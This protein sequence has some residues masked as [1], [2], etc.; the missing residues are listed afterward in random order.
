MRPESPLGVSLRARLAP[1]ED[2]EKVLNAM[3]GI[4]RGS[5]H[6]VEAT[7]RELRVES[8]DPGSLDG[9]RDQ[10]RDRH[11]RAAVRRRLV[12]G[13]SGHKTTV[14][15]NRQ[16]ATAGVVAIC[17]SEEESPLGPIYLTIDSDRLD[18][19]IDWLTNVQTG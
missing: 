8:S 4:L 18:E 15:I 10:S 17:D 19:V 6:T 3:K 2:A 1:S 13:R 7:P 9:I 12:A 11:V 16:A 14:M 5:S